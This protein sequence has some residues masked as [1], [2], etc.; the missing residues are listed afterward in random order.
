M[1]DVKGKQL[2][3][4]VHSMSKGREVRV[5]G[6]DVTLVFRFG[7]LFSDELGSKIRVCI[8]S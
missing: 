5:F 1:R 4:V 2:M 3:L 6:L 8:G 7:S